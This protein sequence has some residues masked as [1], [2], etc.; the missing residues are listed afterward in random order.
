MPTPP[1]MEFEKLKLLFDYTKFHIGVYITLGT[2]LVAVLGA[3]TKLDSVIV[4]HRPWLTAATAFIATAG[5]AGGVLVSSMCDADGITTFWKTKLGPWSLEIMQARYWA[6]LEHTT[7][8][9]GLLCAFLA[10]AG[11]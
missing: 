8:W 5:V 3:A 11:K 7:F 2:A 1:D 10:F 6:Y 9:L 4:V